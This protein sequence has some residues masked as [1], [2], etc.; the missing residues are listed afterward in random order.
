MENFNYYNPV[1]VVFGAK[2]VKEIGS[3]ASQYGKKALLVS[4]KEVSYIQS[5]IDCIHT[6]L[7]KNG[8]AYTDFFQV[9]ANPL[10]S[11]ARAGI[12]T[13]INENVDVIIGLGGGSVMDCAK[14]IAAGVLYDGDIE[15]MIMF[16]HSEI[17][18]VSPTKALPTIMIPTLPATGSEMNPTAVITDDKTNKKSYVWE[19]SCLYPKVAILDPELTLTLPVY[20]TACGAFDIVS[21]IVEAYLNGNTEY[22]LD[23]LDRMQE[24]GY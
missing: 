3:Y 4:Y 8:V 17:K 18:S 20:Q 16:S 15:N 13:A 6:E 1:K 2:T 9:T 7:S 24:G 5:V 12:E 10:L 21:H 11:Q 14:I 22:D 23:V 19:P